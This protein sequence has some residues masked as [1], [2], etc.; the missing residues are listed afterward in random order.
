MARQL[1][2]TVLLVRFGDGD[3]IAAEAKYHKPCL[4]KFYT[5]HR[6]NQRAQIVHSDVEQGITAERVILEVVEDIK[7]KATAGKS[8]FPLSKLVKE[9]QDRRGQLGLSKN[10]NATRLKDRIIEE[11]QGDL[12]EHGT[13]YD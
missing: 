12:V 4:T 1:E 5:R 11:F 6:S 13:Q 10:V 3:L 8:I 2:D 7:E 9:V